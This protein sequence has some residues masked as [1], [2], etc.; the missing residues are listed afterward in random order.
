MEFIKKYKVVLA[1]VLTVLILVLIRSFGANH[2][3]SDAKRWAEPSVMRSNLITPEQ[4]GTLSGKK[5]VICLDEYV[6]ENNE[7]PKDAIYIHADSILNKNNL[8]IIRN[9]V[10][11][12]LLVSSDMAIS[13]RIW[14]VLCQ[15][16]YS[17][18][19]IYTGITD[20][21]IFKYKFRPDTIVRPEL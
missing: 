19:Y 9:H 17:N 5:L 3:K 6:A 15:M 18:I 16:G 13:A 20:N 8:H 21:E 7:V 11:P 2:F 10:G 1:I 14:M 12:I 4:A